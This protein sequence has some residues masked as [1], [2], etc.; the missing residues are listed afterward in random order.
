MEEQKIESWKRESQ[1]KNEL[2]N[3]QETYFVARKKVKEAQ[4]ESFRASDELR[5]VQEEL[6]IAHRKAIECCVVSAK[7]QNDLPPSP[8]SNLQ[9][10]YYR[11]NENIAILSNQINANEYGVDKVIHRKT[12]DLAIRALTAKQSTLNDFHD[13]RNDE[14]EKF[15]NRSKSTKYGALCFSSGG[16]FIEDVKAVRLTEKL[17]ND[18]YRNSDLSFTISI[19][20]ESLFVRRSVFLA[21]VVI[22]LGFLIRFAVLSQETA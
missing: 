2:Q 19:F 10:G 5:I 9:N 16:N 13:K 3:Y 11:D 12:D 17:P 15:V 18:C 6:K 20:L 14:Y 7:I 22:F 4:K 21:F 8:F 1:Y